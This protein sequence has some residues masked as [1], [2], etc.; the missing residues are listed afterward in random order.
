MQHGVDAMIDCIPPRDFDRRIKLGLLAKQAIQLLT[1]GRD[2]GVIDFMRLYV[3]IM[4][5]GECPFCGVPQ[6][7][8][9]V[10]IGVLAQIPH[11]R[12]ALKLH[13]SGI[14][15]QGSNDNLHEGGL[16]LTVA[17]DEPDLLPGI[18]STGRPVEHDQRAVGMLQV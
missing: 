4:Q 10:K 7:V 8:R 11:S 2:H 9:G 6:R 13:C 17:S 15:L 3:Q 14:R 18:H 5:L 1:L 12:A 16:A